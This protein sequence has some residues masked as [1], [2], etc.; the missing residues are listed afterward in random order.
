MTIMLRGLT[1]HSAARV[2]VSA[3]LT[4]SAAAVAMASAVMV[5]LVTTKKVVAALDPV[6]LAL[7]RTRAL[8]EEA[9][10]SVEVAVHQ[11]IRPCS[12][13]GSP[14]VSPKTRS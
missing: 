13:M 5:I 10:A 3:T 4:D 11:A 1:P 9:V 7:A 14:T 12:S 8:E 6:D 2:K